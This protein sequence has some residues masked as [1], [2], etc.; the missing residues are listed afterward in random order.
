MWGNE[1]EIRAKA[2][3]EHR[4]LML[5]NCL[6]LG[7]DGSVWVIHDKTE[8]DRWAVKLHRH[9]S[10]YLRERDCYQRLHE[11]GIIHILG[12]H[13]PQLLRWDDD[14]MAI[15]MSLVAMPFLVDFASAWLDEPPE[16]STEVWDEWE[17]D[18]SEKFEHHWPTAKAVIRTLETLGIY[19]TDVHPGNLAFPDGEGFET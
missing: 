2:Y 5:G 1:I 16:F 13:V 6:G 8:P 9:R 10:A 4:Q 14:W 11:L 3:G 12:F 17:A 7:A 18:R 19:L 15:E